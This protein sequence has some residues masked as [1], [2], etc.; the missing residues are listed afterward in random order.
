MLHLIHAATQGQLDA[1]YTY[2]ATVKAYAALDDPSPA[3]TG[4]FVR[5]SSFLRSAERAEK[6]GRAAAEFGREAVKATKSTAKRLRDTAYLIKISSAPAER[7][8]P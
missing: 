3:V 6:K 2:D 4:R 5:S 1:Q 7:P 8:W